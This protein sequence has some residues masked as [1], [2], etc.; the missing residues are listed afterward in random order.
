MDK[1]KKYQVEPCIIPY[2]FKNV[3]RYY[4][5]DLRIVYT[6]GTSELVEI[7]PEGK[8]FRNDPK[9][10]AKWKAARQ[11]C[12]RRK[13]EITFKVVGYEELN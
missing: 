11:W 5:P 6:D 13:R 12:K 10:I 8:H 7:K 4:L 1:V 2:E 9:N 3:T